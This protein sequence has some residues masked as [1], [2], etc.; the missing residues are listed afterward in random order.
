MPTL[1]NLPIDPFYHAD[2][3]IIY[4]QFDGAKEEKLARLGDNQTVKYQDKK[5]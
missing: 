1:V 4:R 5:K 3:R 2:G